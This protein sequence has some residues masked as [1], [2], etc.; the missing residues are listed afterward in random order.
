MSSGISCC[1]N[2]WARWMFLLDQFIWRGGGGVGGTNDGPSWPPCTFLSFWAGTKQQKFICQS[3]RKIV[4]TWCGLPSVRSRGRLP[5]RQISRLRGAVG[6]A[7]ECRLSDRRQRGAKC[8]R[9]GGRHRRNA[10]AMWRSSGFRQ[11]GAT[12]TCMCVPSTSLNYGSA[13]S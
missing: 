7:E 9:K 3:S 11:A 6:G 5:A 4:F 13:S 10:V 8:P 2:T 12:H 1:G